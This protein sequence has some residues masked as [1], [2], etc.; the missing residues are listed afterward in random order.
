MQRPMRK[1][2]REVSQTET[3]LLLQ[4]G[5]YGVLATAGANGQPYATPLSYVYRGSALYFHC[6]HEGLKIDN[7]RANPAVSF[8]VVGQTKVLPSQFSTEYESA[9]VF[10]NANEVIGEEKA[11]ALL[12]LIEKYSPEFVEKGRV[13][14][15]NMIEE[16]TVVRIDITRLS[17][18][19]RRKKAADA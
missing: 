12:W 11:D 1:K 6:A 8:C 19:A 18:K 9:V 17:G 7:L 16:T 3:E 15:A 10:G 4:E 2:N 5:A 13:Y 14:I